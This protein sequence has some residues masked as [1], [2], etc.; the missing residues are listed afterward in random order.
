M[1][2]LSMSRAGLVGL[3]AA[4]VVMGT[5]GCG[6]SSAAGAGMDP[7]YISS[8]EVEAAVTVDNARALVERLRPRW[9]ET[10]G[11]DQRFHVGGVRTVND[12]EGGGNEG[13]SVYI[14]RTRVGTSGALRSIPRIDIASLRYLRPERAQL[15]FGATNGLGAIVVELKGGDEQVSLSP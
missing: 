10:R 6:S 8:A 4:V 11:G 9:L 1:A 7:N 15:E 13:V 14:G 5:T 2:L 3:I 12:R